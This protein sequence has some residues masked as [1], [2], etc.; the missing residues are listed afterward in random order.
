[1]I[2]YIVGFI[3]CLFVWASFKPHVI[4]S[5]GSN[6]AVM[7]F[8]WGKLFGSKLIFIETRARVYSKSH[9]GRIV[10]SLC[11]KIIVQWPEMLRVYKNSEY[12]GTLA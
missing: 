8:I 5:T 10:E 11:D 9:T 1:V 7:M 2:N 3:Q 6:I 4:I 12:W